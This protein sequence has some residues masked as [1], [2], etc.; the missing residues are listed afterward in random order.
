VRWP[1]SLLTKVNTSDIRQ[2]R[3][4]TPSTA[5]GVLLSDLAFTTPAAGTGAPTTLPQLAVTGTT[6]N[7]NAGTATVTVAL[8][9]ASTVPVTVHLQAMTGASTQITAAARQVVIPAGQTSVA[10]SVPVL[11]DSTVEPTADTRY[12]VVL[13]YPANAVTGQNTAYVTVHD[14]EA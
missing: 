13:G 12:E 1:V 11:D 6:V 5:G 3:I 8:S 14:D 4:T 10:V 9:K 2:I 7:E